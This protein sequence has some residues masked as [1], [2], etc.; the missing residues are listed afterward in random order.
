[1]FL[2]VVNGE[3]YVQYCDNI[4]NNKAD[5][6]IQRFTGNWNP[7]LVKQQEIYYSKYRMFYVSQTFN[8]LKYNLLPTWLSSSAWF[9]QQITEV[10]N[11]ANYNGEPYENYNSL[12]AKYVNV[13][14][15][16]ELVFSRN[17]QNISIT[18][19]YTIATVEIP[20][21]YLNGIDLNPKDLV[22]ETNTVL[23]EDGNVIT[24][25]IY[26]VLYLNYLNTINVIDNN[27]SIIESSG[28]YINTNI[29][30]GTST[31]YN[32]TR[33]SK[34]LINYEDT[35]TKIFPIG[36]DAIDDTHKSCE[37]TIY[38]DKAIS[39]IEFISNDETTTYITIIQEL[40]VGKY[41]T[42][43]QYLKVE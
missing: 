25:N 38:V 5:Y 26:E 17:L 12:K 41:Y 31:N 40:E 33:C 39:S 21:T 11:L 35:T 4:A 36:W 7:I 43:K 32:N 30:V 18:N 13:Y 28:R 24:K 9:M 14:S 42:F 8:L 22:G 10:Y 20:N 27:N 19:N 34:V 6:Y 2:Q 23:V 15:N 29:N 1:M 3:L 16:N 37:F